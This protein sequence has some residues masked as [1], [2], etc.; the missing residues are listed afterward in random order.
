MVDPITTFI[1]AGTSGE[2]EAMLTRLIDFLKARQT[3]AVFTSLTRGGDALEGS[4]V[5]VS[6]L[7]DVWL[8]VRH[9]EERGERIRGLYVL[10]SRGMAHSNR[11][12]EFVLTN[13][14]VDLLDIDVENGRPAASL[15]R[16]A[17]HKGGGAR[18]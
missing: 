4:Q 1:G 13:E 6:S 2:A 12:R 14:G 5:A 16:P 9:I 17:R 10:K 18:K 8:L 15:V 7:I 3:T 11:I